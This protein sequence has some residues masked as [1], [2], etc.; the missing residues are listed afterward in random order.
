M[1][2]SRNTYVV[3][4]AQT[5]SASVE[6]STLP[7]TP[8]ESGDRSGE[9]EAHDEDELDIPP[10]LPADDR[11][12]AQVADIGHTRLVTGLQDHPANVG[13]PETLV[14]VVRVKVGVGVTMVRAVAAA[15]PFDRA[16]DGTSTRDREHVLQRL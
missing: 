8:A 10:V 12:L 7:V 16:L 15:P 4:E 2:C 9:Q 14:R 13:E 5:G 6:E 11:V 1:L 3:D